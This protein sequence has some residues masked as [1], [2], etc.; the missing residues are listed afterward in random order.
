MAIG[1]VYRDPVL[2]VQQ[3]GVFVTR[4]HEQV[5]KQGGESTG[6]H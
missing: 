4:R 5:A 1:R 6:E 2:F 3:E